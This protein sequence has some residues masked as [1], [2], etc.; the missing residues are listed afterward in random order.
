MDPSISQSAEVI[1][2]EPN[3]I[4]S[5]EILDIPLEYNDISISSSLADM[6]KGKNLYRFL[7]C[8]VYL[9]EDHEEQPR[10]I[11]IECLSVSIPGEKVIPVGDYIMPD[12]C[13]FLTV[14]RNMSINRKIYIE[15]NEIKGVY[16]SKHFKYFEA[17]NH[18]Y[19]ALF[20]VNN[21]L[22]FLELLE[23]TENCLKFD[24][25]R[26]FEINKISP[27]ANF[28][29]FGIE[30]PGMDKYGLTGHVKYENFIKSLNDDPICGEFSF[31][32]K[33]RELCGVPWMSSASEQ[34][35]AQI[36]GIVDRLQESIEEPGIG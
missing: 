12:G 32:M 11:L 3:E 27:F 21:K 36:K 1:D 8:E 25:N 18:L 15:F 14:S 13:E 29:Y 33:E 34:E 28:Y 23:E 20:T 5:P 19:G 17:S 35:K 30:N 24:E 10:D 6:V 9:D 4:V 26:Y 7:D 2:N 22:Y 16:E 31:F